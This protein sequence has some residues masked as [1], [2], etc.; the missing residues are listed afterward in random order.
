[1]SAIA[2]PSVSFTNSTNPSKLYPVED[3]RTAEKIDIPAGP[4]QPASEA[5]YAILFTFKEGCVPQRD[6]ADFLTSGARNTSFTN[7]QT[8]ISTAI[9]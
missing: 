8:A 3:I 4:N 5:R 9:V 7:L 6:R 1:M 2:K